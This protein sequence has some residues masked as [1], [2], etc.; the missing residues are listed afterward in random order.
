[1]EFKKE[2]LFKEIVNDS[3]SFAKE[4]AKELFLVVFIFASPFALV[5]GY[6]Y[7][8]IQLSELTSSEYGVPALNYAGYYGSM[9]LANVMMIL[10]VYGYVYFYIKQGK[11]NFT[12][13]DVWQY[14]THHFTKILGA[15]ISIV[16]LLVLGFLLLLVP[17]IYL[18][19][20]VMFMFSVLLYEQQDYPIAFMRCFMI[21]KDRWWYT[22]G[23]FLFINGIILVFSLLMMIPE[24]T[25]SYIVKAEGTNAG[26]WAVR[27]AVTSTVTQYLVFFLQV[28]PH[29][30]VI[31]QYF[32]LSAEKERL[33]AKNQ[34]EQVPTGI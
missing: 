17:G 14:L 9:L 20:I 29:I 32:N 15:I 16:M 28:I 25:V 11:G 6:F 18:S 23:L 24:F 31:L 12:R 4:N 8:R 3:F 2:R 34:Q 7:S 26:P 21:T 33:N 13:D 27:F 5:S 30:A 10:C 1:M 19:I 22:L